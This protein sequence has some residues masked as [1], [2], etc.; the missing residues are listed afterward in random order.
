M[1]FHRYREEQVDAVAEFARWS[2]FLIV[3]A[4]L[5]LLALSSAAGVGAVLR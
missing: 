1:N 5:V 4:A 2:A 3:A